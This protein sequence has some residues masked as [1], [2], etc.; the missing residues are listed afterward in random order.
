ERRHRNIE[1]VEMLLANQI[2]QQVEWPFERLKKN[3]KRIGRDVQVVWES[4][5]RLAVKPGQRD[6]IDG[7]KGA[8]R[9]GGFQRSHRF[10][11]EQIRRAAVQLFRLARRKLRS[12]DVGRLRDVGSLEALV[13]IGINILVPK[14]G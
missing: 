2:E 3:L 5:Q 8:V 4:E 9:C 1:H 13:K 7:V 12:I 14:Y 10:R 11:I 6:V